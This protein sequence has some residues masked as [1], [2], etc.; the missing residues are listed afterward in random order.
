MRQLRDEIL[1]SRDRDALKRLV[2]QV[3]AKRQF[4][5]QDPGAKAVSKMLEHLEKIDHFKE[6]AVDKEILQ[7]N[8][9]HLTKS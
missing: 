9:P 8:P 6:K 5:K 4:K 1:Q 2:A 7:P 3:Q